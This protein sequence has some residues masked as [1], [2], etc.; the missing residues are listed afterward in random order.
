MLLHLSDLIARRKRLTLPNDKRCPY[1]WTTKPYPEQTSL[2]FWAFVTTLNA[3]NWQ[4][5][6]PGYLANTG[7]FGN[8][9]WH[10]RLVLVELGR[11]PSFTPLA[12]PHPD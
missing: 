10:Y 7:T 2:F 8:Q 5:Q 4:V 9:C 12:L 1:S 3:D 11:P 6:P